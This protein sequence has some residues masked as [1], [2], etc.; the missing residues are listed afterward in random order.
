M[1]EGTAALVVGSVG[2]IG[3]LASAL[4]TYRQAERTHRADRDHSDLRSAERERHRL[5]EVRTAQYA[6]LN[7]AAR[8]YLTA[9][10]DYCH[11]LRRG[12]DPGEAANVLHTVRAAYRNTYAQAQMTVPAPVLEALRTANRTL[13]ALYG[14]LMRLTPD[15]DGTAVEAAEAEIRRCWTRL[16]ELRT[17]LRSD[18]GLVPGLEPGPGPGLEP[19]P[20]IAAPA[21]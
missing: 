14:S 5:R 8:Q 21:R 9:L 20:G 11:V 19:G 6:E 16:T 15:P 1:G 12:A 17:S 10:S 2:I 3:T 18:L 7:A 4:L 13:G